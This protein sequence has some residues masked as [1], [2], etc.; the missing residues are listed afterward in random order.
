MIWMA[1]ALLTCLLAG[2]S[3]NRSLLALALVQGILVLA[4][5]RIGTFV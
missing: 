3:S 5:W 4:A 1:F 2:L